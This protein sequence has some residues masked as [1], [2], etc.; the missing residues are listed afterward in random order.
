MEEFTNIAV[1]DQTEE[2]IFSDAEETV[3][4]EGWLK[5]F[6]RQLSS[7]R[8]GK[9]LEALPLMD[10]AIKPAMA[11]LTD[12]LI[13]ETSGENGLLVR[14]FRKQIRQYDP[15]RNP[16]GPYEARAIMMSMLDLAA[17]RRKLLN[18]R[19]EQ[20]AEIGGLYK[21]YYGRI[22][23]VTDLA[24]QASTDLER[25]DLAEEDYRYYY[26]MLLN[27]R[28]RSVVTEIQ[29]EEEERQVL[30]SLR[31]R[32]RK[33]SNDVMLELKKR[34]EEGCGTESTSEIPED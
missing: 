5:H 2:Q 10:S 34:G 3:E 7:R 16:I 11:H 33:R 30:K 28:D 15:E 31:D 8:T 6:F 29:P 24:I 12:E 20:S 14:E 21:Q 32:M 19:L 13:E 26:S 27:V 25:M 18:E 1:E 23:E 9:Q 22:D 4:K 17:S